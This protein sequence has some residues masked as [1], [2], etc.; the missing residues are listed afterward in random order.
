[1]SYSI[2][3]GVS[4]MSVIN[5][6]SAILSCLV[7]LLIATSRLLADAPHRCGDDTTNY[8]GAILFT[9]LLHNFAPTSASTPIPLALTVLVAVR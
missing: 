6:Q 1:M 3:N 2:S 8:C 9:D 4:A 7:G 5:I